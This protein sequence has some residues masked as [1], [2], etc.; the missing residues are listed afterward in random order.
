MDVGTSPGNRLVALTSAI[1]PGHR[2]DA[3][4]ATEHAPGQGLQS[5]ADISN[6]DR[7]K[8]PYHEA[9]GSCFRSSSS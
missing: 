7:S 8:P 1:D 5:P 3:P 9:T 2:S 6:R 4:V